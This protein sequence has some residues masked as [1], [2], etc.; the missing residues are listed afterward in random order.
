MEPTG[1]Y[2][3]ANHQVDVFIFI[4]ALIGLALGIVGGVPV[5]VTRV[6]VPKVNADNKVITVKKY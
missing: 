3:Q 6:Q 2:G 1:K 5:S 4:N